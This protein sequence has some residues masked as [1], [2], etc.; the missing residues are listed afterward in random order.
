MIDKYYFEP[1][2]TLCRGFNTE[3]SVEDIR[4][5]LK[6]GKELSEDEQKFIN[7][8]TKLGLFP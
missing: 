3:F 1:Y 5:R 8:I 4:V 2:K 7:H 6:R